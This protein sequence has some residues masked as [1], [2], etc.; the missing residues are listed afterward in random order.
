MFCFVALVGFVTAYD[1]SEYPP[2]GKVPPANHTWTNIVRQRISG[3]PSMVTQCNNQGTWAQTWDDGPSDHTHIVLDALKAKKVKATFF[4]TGSQVRQF[5]SVL[6]RAFDEGHQIALHSW[7]H[8]NLLTIG[9]SEV[10]AEL[11]WSARIVRE[12]IGVTPRMFRPPFGSY[13]DEILQTLEALGFRVIYWD[14]DTND[15]NFSF[16]P[17]ESPGS[18]YPPF[19]T[20]DE[21]TK[22]FRRWTQDRYRRSISL[23]HDLQ[24][25]PSKQAGSSVDVIL[26]A[27]YKMETV[28]QCINEAA[29]DDQI[30]TRLG[31]QFTQRST[32]QESLTPSV[33]PD[34]VQFS[35]STSVVSTVIVPNATVGP[36]EAKTNGATWL[37]DISFVLLV[38]LAFLLF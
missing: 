34:S 35:L 2:A 23:Q 25:E 37:R 10:I 28:A 13:N 19:A 38:P 17:D 31:I 29:Y 1:F 24:L 22:Q 18:K 5:P 33:A 7:S 32:I 8:T 21:I 36:T 11:V 3:W 20:P 27:G 9:R 14:L 6:K 16:Y 12:V 4:V 26:G 30:L 15:W